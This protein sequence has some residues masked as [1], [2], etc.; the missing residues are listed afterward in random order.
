MKVVWTA[1]ALG[2]L[3]GIDETIAADST[4]YEFSADG[5]RLVDYR[6]TEHYRPAGAHAAAAV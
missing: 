4:T 6:D 1:T 3:T 5:I 2:H